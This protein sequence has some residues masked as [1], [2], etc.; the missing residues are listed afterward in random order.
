MSDKD[1]GMIVSA[2]LIS[3]SFDLAF[4][5]ISNRTEEESLKETKKNLRKY[6]VGK[7]FSKITEMKNVE[8][9]ILIK[10]YRM[11][12]KYEN[13]EILICDLINLKE[14]KFIENAKI[15]M[16]EFGEGLFY[17][18]DDIIY[19]EINESLFKEELNK[20]RSIK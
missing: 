12:K 16:L 15:S 20:I 2:E 1:I 7:Y 9:Y 17:T 19:K 18:V 10:G 14:K 11:G 8:E 3:E 6:Y 13:K 5:K 4:E